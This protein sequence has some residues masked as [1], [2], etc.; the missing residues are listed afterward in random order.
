MRLEVRRAT[1]SIDEV[2]RSKGRPPTMSMKYLLLLGAL[3]AVPTIIAG[4]SQSKATYPPGATIQ[5]PPTKAAAKEVP[6]STQEQ[7]DSKG[8][9]STPPTAEEKAPM[10][11]EYLAELAKIHEPPEMAGKPMQVRKAVSPSWLK[12]EN[13]MSAAGAEKATHEQRSAAIRELVEIA[14]SKALDDFERVSTYGAL[15]A[16]ACSDGANPQTV[17]GYANDAIGDDHDDHVL[18]L[19]ARMYLKAG[20]RDK[21]FADLEKVMADGHGQPLRR[22]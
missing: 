8:Y 18:A 17:I 22:R 2:I 11:P 12:L 15:A 1:R 19:R 6:G 13:L 14:N 10:R 4:C 9:S 3:L 7:S 5:Q 21:A 20:D 16:M